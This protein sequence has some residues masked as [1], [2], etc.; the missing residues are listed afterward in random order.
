MLPPV[1]K[2]KKK[3]LLTFVFLLD[4]THNYLTIWQKG[5]MISEDQHKLFTLERYYIDILSRDDISLLNS[6]EL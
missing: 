6:E 3:N 4:L 1:K 5:K 2:N